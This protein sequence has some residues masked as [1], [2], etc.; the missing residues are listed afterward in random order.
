MDLEFFDCNAF[1]GSAQTGTWKPAADRSGILAAMDEAG[2][3]K[4]LIWH[5][6]QQDWS[7]PE[8]NDLA[9]AA[10]GDERRLWGCW[11]ILP[12][13]TGELPQ[14]PELFARMKSERI[15]ALRIF[16]NDHR[17]VPGRTAL[18][19]LL[20]EAVKR[21]LPLFLS[22]ERGGTDY[23]VIDRLLGEFPRLR[24]VLCDVGIWGVDRFIRPLLERFPGVRVETSYLALHDGVLEELVRRY[25]ARRLL[26]G[27]GFPARLPASAMLP[28]L[29]APIDEEDKRMIAAGNLEGL[30]AEV[31]L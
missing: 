25:G 26:F 19:S 2:I 3:D 10:V 30:L 7:I 27:T 12:P 29:H 21:R 15:R 5:V 24:C 17:Y 11:T 6:G 8:G 13:H 31:K 23:P 16:P 14:A 1:I 20:D 4:A 22:V 18:G 28:L 9:S